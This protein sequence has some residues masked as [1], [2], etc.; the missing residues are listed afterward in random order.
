MKVAAHA[1]MRQVHLTF[2]T[3]FKIRKPCHDNYAARLS[4]GLG[5]LWSSVAIA[6]MRDGR[7][8]AA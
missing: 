7:A 2:P 3:F 5:S 6:G 4:I 8:A 1:S